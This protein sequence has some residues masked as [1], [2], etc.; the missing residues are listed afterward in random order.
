[1]SINAVP[2]ADVLVDG[3]AAGQTPLANVSLPIGPHEIVFRHPQ[4]GERKRTVVVTVEGLAKV[5]Q[6]FQ[7]GGGSQ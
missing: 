1:V 4:L 6:T 5:T 2:W 3:S 7:A